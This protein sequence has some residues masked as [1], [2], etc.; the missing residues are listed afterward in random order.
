M[1]LQ[2][3]GLIFTLDFIC[4]PFS[5]LANMVAFVLDFQVGI[6]SGWLQCSGSLRVT[7]SDIFLPTFFLVGEA[8][9]LRAHRC[10]F[11]GVSP[12]ALNCAAANLVMWSL[13]LI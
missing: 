7:G 9:G 4:R 1:E 13:F 2:W 5:L 3:N 12:V 6:S 11:P 8:Q 10:L